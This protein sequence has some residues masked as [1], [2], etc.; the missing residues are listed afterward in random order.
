MAR[1]PHRAEFVKTKKG[2]LLLCHE[3]FEYHETGSRAET[4]Y[5]ICTKRPECS[6]RAIKGT[7]PHDARVTKAGGHTSHALNREETSARRVVNE[8]KDVAARHPEMPPAN[9]IRAGLADVDDEVLAQM[10]QRLALKRA[11]NRKRQADLP[12]NPI[13]LGDIRELPEEY[14]KTLAVDDLTTDMMVVD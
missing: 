14:R 6:A 13:A 3:G 11:P 2:G 7:L 4:T 12:R 10:P 9:I 1:A 5:W 8:L